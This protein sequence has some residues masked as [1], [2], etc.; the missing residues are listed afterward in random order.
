MKVLRE[1][2]DHD[3]NELNFHDNIIYSVSFPDEEPLFSIRLDYIL[4]W[5]L[6]RSQG[7][8]SFLVSPAI[9]VFENISKLKIDLNYENNIGM[10]MS[11]FVRDNQRLAP[12]KEVYLWDYVIYTDRGNI[13]LSASRFSLKLLDD[14]IS[15][16]SQKYPK[17]FEIE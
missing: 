7:L 17:S 12:N 2:T 4:E 15:S 5:N 14:P 11:A 8:Y 6:D 9:I 1:W 3:F 16:H 13:S 10:I